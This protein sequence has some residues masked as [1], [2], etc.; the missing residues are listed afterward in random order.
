MILGVQHMTIAII[1]AAGAI[2]RSVADACNAAGQSV[3]LVGRKPAPL[4]SMKR[5]GDT[6]VGADVA[7]DA[8]CRAALEG[9]DSAVYTLG[10]P[11]SKEAFAAYPGMMRMCLDAARDA[12]TKRLLLITNVYPYGLP[13]S[14]RVAESHPRN[15]CSVKG[16]YRKEQEDILLSA[17]GQGLETISLRLPDFYGANAATSLMGM[18]VKAAAAGQAGNLLGPVDTPHEFVF[19]P[20]VGPVVRGLLEFPGPVSGAYNFAGAG[21]ITQRQLAT[22]I[23]KAAGQAPRLRVMA[24]WMQSLAG[25]FMPVLRE[26]AE[27]RYLLQTPVFLD[28]AK[29][30]A[31]LPAIR[32]TSYEEGAK[33]SVAGARGA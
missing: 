10:L 1:G 32:K 12:G 5:P 17:T 8:G 6:V 2:G 26:L 9:A 15:T 3:R 29:L 14:E 33:L 22:L 18:V 13:Q 27:M 19:T 16:T 21:V 25:L 24:P 4:E 23:Y 20:D 7:T 31:L 11:Y 30:L 28:D